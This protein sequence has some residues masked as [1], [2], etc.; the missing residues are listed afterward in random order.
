MPN[1]SWDSSQIEKL[2]F[3]FCKRYL[4]VNSK[5]SNVGWRAEL[6]LSPLNITINQKILNNTFYI[7][8]LKM[9]KLSLS[10]LFKC[11]K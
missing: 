6:G 5:A 4:E 2:L 3:Q 8:S 1:Q 10:N 9:K 7:L 11:H